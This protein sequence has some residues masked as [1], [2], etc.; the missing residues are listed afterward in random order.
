MNQIGDNALEP[1][2]IENTEINVLLFNKSKKEKIPVTS[3]SEAIS[4]IKDQDFG[5]K[6]IE[7]DGEIV[8][9][10][11]RHGSI[12]RWEKEWKRQKRKMSLTE[13][14][15]DCPFDVDACYKNDL[16][17]DCKMKEAAGK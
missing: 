5:T 17:I 13:S 6:K 12:E 1:T 10:S 11:E 16:C 2:E 3:I 9:F 7:L 15:R 4:E 14:T 8:Y